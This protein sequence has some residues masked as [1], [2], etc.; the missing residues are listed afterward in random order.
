MGLR[1]SETLLSNQ[2]SPFI[3]RLCET[4]LTLFCRRNLVSGKWIPPLHPHTHTLQTVFQ[5][6]YIIYTLSQHCLF[7]FCLLV[8]KEL[9]SEFLSYT[10]LIF[11]NCNF[12][13]NHVPRKKCVGAEDVRG[14]VERESRIPVRQIYSTRE[15]LN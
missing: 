5:K 14:G 1:D 6:I 11:L 12:R 15:K 4:F 13:N 10:S 2:A 9:K 8:L 3:S 7:A